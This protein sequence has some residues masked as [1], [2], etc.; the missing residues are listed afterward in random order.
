MALTLI[1]LRHAKSGW[2]NPSL[3]DHARA[4][5]DRG[6][7]DA[8]AVGVWLGARDLVP[9]LI[10]SSDATRTRQTVADLSGGLGQDVPTEF[11]PSLYNA[12]SDTI[13]RTIRKQSGKV[14][15]LC[16]HNPGIGNVA[17]AL[18]PEPPE[19][20]RFDDYPTAATTVLS[21]DA[22]NWSDIK[23]GACLSFVIPADLKT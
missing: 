6:H 14:L 8:R 21:F 5:T 4:L 18:A 16:A 7:R 17:A 2:G 23:T 12:S 9:D 15:L 19:H 1:V 20:P 11:L 3:P 22:D 13:E 10:L